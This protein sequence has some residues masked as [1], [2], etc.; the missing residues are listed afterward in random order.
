MT[1]SQT[2]KTTTS[3]S[4]NNFE[5]P[6]KFYGNVYRKGSLESKFKN[7]IQTTVSG[8]KH[9]IITDKNKIVHRKLTS[10]PLPFQQP[11]TAPTKQI[12]T[13]TTTPTN[14]PASKH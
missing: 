5:Y 8:T 13:A 14:L 4:M 3:V 10:N 9:T 7:K 1:F 2:K 12:S 11:T 6:L